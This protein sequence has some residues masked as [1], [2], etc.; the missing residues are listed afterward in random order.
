MRIALPP[1]ARGRWCDVEGMP[2][3][4]FCWVEQIAES[5]EL[6]ALPSRL[7]QHG[8]VVGRNLESLLVCFPDRQV[9]SL[10]PHLVRVLEEAPGER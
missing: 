9:I 2:V 4:L 3:A 5:A 6:T 8:Q 7:H 10:Q 1:P